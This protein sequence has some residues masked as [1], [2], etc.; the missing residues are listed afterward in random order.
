MDKSY[1]AFLIQTILYGTC[2]DKKKSKTIEIFLGI[3]RE[4]YNNVY[5]IF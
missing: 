3:R 1:G 2:F 5:G 4:I